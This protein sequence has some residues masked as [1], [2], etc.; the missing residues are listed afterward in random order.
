MAQ[1]TR[2]KFSFEMSKPGQ[3]QQ[4]KTVEGKNNRQRTKLE[5]TEIKK[6]RMR[7]KESAAN[8]K[9]TKY[10]M[11]KEYKENIEKIKRE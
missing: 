4:C 7:K 3:L 9:S 10:R 6:G 1:T 5:K 8:E 2:T 11:F